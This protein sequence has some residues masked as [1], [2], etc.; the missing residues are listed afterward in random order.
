MTY[1]RLVALVQALFVGM[2]SAAI[3]LGLF[4]WW[5]APEWWLVGYA[6]TIGAGMYAGALYLDRKRNTAPPTQGGD[7]GE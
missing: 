3:G 6:A 1:V 5:L 7:H 2:I 4:W